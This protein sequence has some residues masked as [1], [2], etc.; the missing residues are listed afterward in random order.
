MIRELKRSIKKALP[1]WI[2]ARIS[3]N[4]W[5]KFLWKACERNG[6]HEVSRKLIANNG[7]VVRW[8]PFAGLKLPPKAVLASG[9]CA[10]LVGTYE[11]EIHPWLEQLVP[12][13][14]ERILDIGAAEGYYAIGMALRTRSR[15]DAFDT[16]SIARRLCRATAR[17]NGVSHLVR[18]HSFCSRQTLLSLAGLRCFILSDCEGYEA[19]LFSADVIGAL[20]RSDLI[21]ELHDGLAPAGTTRQ[22]LREQ[23]GTTHRVQ[24]VQFRPRDLSSFPDPVLAAMLGADAIRVIS[25][26]GRLP[27]QEWLVATALHEGSS[28]GSA[29][30]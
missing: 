8:G 4:R 26:E 12:G 14:Y 11:M 18:V 27:D 24:V 20:S 6:L 5:W 19:S 28:G 30:V 3:A 16:A 7:V 21:I 17:V 29:A 22:L 9:N 23:F 25:E 10:A 1:H 2:V 15:V 13:Q